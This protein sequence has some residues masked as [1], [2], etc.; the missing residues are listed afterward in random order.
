MGSSLSPVH[1]EGKIVDLHGVK[2]ESI[3]LG[4]SVAYTYEGNSTTAKD[5]DGVVIVANKMDIVTL[6]NE[7]RKS[8]CNILSIVKEECPSLQ[9]P[10]PTHPLWSEFDGVR[11][12]G[13]TANKTKRGVKVLHLEYFR[14]D[15]LSFNLLSFKDKRI[16]FSQALGCSIPYTILQQVTAVDRNLAILHEYTVYTGS[17][18]TNDQGRRQTVA[19]FG[20]T[21]N[22][23]L[24][25][26]CVYGNESIGVLLKGHLLRQFVQVAGTLPSVESLPQYSRFHP[27]YAD[28]L[29]QE[30]AALGPN[31]RPCQPIS[32]HPYYFGPSPTTNTD[33]CKL[34]LRASDESSTPLPEHCDL[35]PYT[36]IAFHS[37]FSSN[38]QHGRLGLVRTPNPLT[39][40][41]W[42][43]PCDL[44]AEIS[45][46]LMAGRYFPRVQYP[47]MCSS[48]ELIYDWFEGSTQAELRLSYLNSM[49]ET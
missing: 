1:F 33:I 20:V 27:S 7:N 13:W 47:R 17:S 6:L 45:G 19:V 46:S 8:L 42:K 29:V 48:E 49:Q 25:A 41:F 11:F 12:V 37:P 5:W 4:G 26:K 24:T 14:G 30:F 23:L 31:I 3:M 38:S 18:L 21:A 16:F 36:R 15:R 32:L 39:G 35:I 28:H 34:H 22:L 40:L 10:E 2:I 43:L 9:V 44:T